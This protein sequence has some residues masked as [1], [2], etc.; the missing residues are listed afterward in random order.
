MTMIEDRPTETPDGFWFVYGLDWNA[1]PIAA[2][3]DADSLARWLQTNG[4]C[5]EAVVFWPFGSA[6]D[7]V[8]R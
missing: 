5:G 1:Y 3:R 2:F 7:E 8:K 6:W 4:G